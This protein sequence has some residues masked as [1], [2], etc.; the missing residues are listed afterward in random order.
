MRSFITPFLMAGATLPTFPAPTG[1]WDAQSSLILSGSNIVSCTDTSGYGN[2]AVGVNT[3]TVSV[4]GGFNWMNFPGSAYLN[5]GSGISMTEPTG[6]TVFA[7]TTIPGFDVHNTVLSNQGATGGSL[8]LILSDGHP[9]FSN[10]SWAGGGTTS[11]IFI[12]AFTNIT[13]PIG[14]PHLLTGRLVPGPTSM[15][16]QVTGDTRSSV[17]Y[18]FSGGSSSGD[19]II[20]DYVRGL[21]SPFTG[22]IAEVILYARGL[23]D[24]DVAIV[25]GYLNTKYSL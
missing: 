9:S 16:I 1:W 14:T 10:K 4:S 5:C 17:G 11:G 15:D 20:G 12:Q 3:P 13:P 7:V 2:T 23:S 19:T 25:Q 21:G 24:S 22:G 6:W 18:G 8:V